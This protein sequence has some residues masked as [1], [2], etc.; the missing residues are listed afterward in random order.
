NY[1]GEMAEAVEQSGGHYSNF[2]GDGLMALFGLEGSSDAG[3]RAALTCALSMLEKLD[4]L[5]E[6]LADELSEPLAMGIGIHTGEAIVGRMGPPKTPILSAIG[7]SVN[8]TARLE[9]TTKEL[10]VP[11]VVSVETLHAAAIRTSMPLEE[12]SLRGRA[13]TMAVAALDKASLRR[14]LI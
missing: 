2:T 3:A 9:S 10:G 13:G 4:N 7:D 14:I 6:Q 11:L 8:T 12:V 1:F 5:N